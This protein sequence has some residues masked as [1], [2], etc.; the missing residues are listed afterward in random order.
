MDKYSAFI[1]WWIYERLCFHWS[2]IWYS[3]DIPLI[4][5]PDLCSHFSVLILGKTGSSKF[6]RFQWHFLCRSLLCSERRILGGW[7]TP[8]IYSLPLTW[9]LFFTFSYQEMFLLIKPFIQCGYQFPG[10]L[11]HFPSIFPYRLSGIQ[12]VMQNDIYWG[13]AHPNYI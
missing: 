8:D 13:P 4:F 7:H 2:V 3:F 11:W 5:H 1:Q 12:K 9:P 10:L 6:Q